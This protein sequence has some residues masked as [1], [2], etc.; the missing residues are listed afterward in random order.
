MTD[1]SLCRRPDTITLV[2]RTGKQVKITIPDGEN[3]EY[4]HEFAMENFA[5]LMDMAGVTVNHIMQ[6]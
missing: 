5:S 2:D 3:T 1:F 6:F 4:E